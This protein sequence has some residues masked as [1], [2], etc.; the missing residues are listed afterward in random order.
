MWRGFW[1]FQMGKSS[2]KF[3]WVLDKLKAERERGITIDI[4]LLKFHTQKHTMTIIDAPGH[5]DFIKNMITGTSQVRSAEVSLSARPCTHPGARFQ[6]DVA[7]LVVSAARGEYEA[8][9][10]RSGQTREHALLAYTL[11]V[12]QIIVCVNKMDLTEPAYSQARFDE[13]VRG[14]GGFLKKIGYDPTGVPFV[15][16][17]GW[18]G[19][20]MITA[21]QKVRTLPVL[22][23]VH[24]ARLMA[25]LPADALVPRLEGQTERGQREWENSA[26]GARLHSAPG[27]HDQQALTVASAGCLQNRR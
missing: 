13:V 6:A 19:E 4:S 11:G 5:R 21:T 25:A 16:I 27:A 14:V 8:G 23:A 26:G 3:A 9:V 7:L 24:A 20:N 22:E 1:V 17:S 12:K 15:P 18:T 10:S 2:F